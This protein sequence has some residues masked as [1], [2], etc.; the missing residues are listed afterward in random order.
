[1]FLYLQALSAALPARAIIPSDSDLTSQRIT[2]RSDD[3]GN[4]FF[5]LPSMDLGEEA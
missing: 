4:L 5:L 2:I 1:M 3:L